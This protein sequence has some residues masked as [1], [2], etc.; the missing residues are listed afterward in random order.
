MKDE[1]D[2]E[3]RACRISGKDR[4]SRWLITYDHATNCVPDWINGGHL[5]I[6][7]ADMAPHIGGRDAQIAAIDPVG[8]AV[9]GVIAG[10]QPA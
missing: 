7:P 2:M 5:G 6:R 8:Y 10:D 1:H 9:G 4:P 3:E